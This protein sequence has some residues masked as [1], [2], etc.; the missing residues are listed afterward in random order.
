M[1][2]GGAP[3]PTK[4]GKRTV[5]FTVNLVPTIDLLS[6]LISFLLITAVWTQLARI[7]ANQMLPKTTDTP[8]EDKQ[9]E[10]KILRLLVADEEV[11]V[12]YGDD[13]P[14][15]IKAGETEMVGKLAESIKALVAQKDKIPDPH[16]QKVQ[17]GAYDNVHYSRL[18]QVMD[19]MLDNELTGL[20]VGGADVLKGMMPDDGSVPG[21]PGSA[22]APGQPG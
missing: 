21:A 9:D 11:I 19:V 6:V 1:A 10:E 12:K 8:Q 14:V 16:K 13:A 18:I 7:N 2:G 4:G 3:A 17:I 22:A 20:S 5:D 15:V